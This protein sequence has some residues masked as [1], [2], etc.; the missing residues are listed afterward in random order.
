MSP[1]V[2]RRYHTFVLWVIVVMIVS[3]CSGR[4]IVTSAEDQAFQAAPPAPVVEET[5]VAPPTQPEEPEMR[6]EEEP[7]APVPETPLPPP[8]DPLSEL[9]DVYFDFDQYAIR[10]DAR[11]TLNRL[12]DLFKSEP[13]QELIIEG[14]CDERG[15]SAYNLVLGERR[16]QAAK[17]YLEKHGVASSQIQTASYGKERP[18]CTEHTEACW[19]SNRRVHFRKP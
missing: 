8:V 18:F 11:S 2:H 19:Q 14:H 13:N 9:S 15:T 7:I 4:R 17:Q 16:A 12:A 3:G 10:V 6:V 5:K 1:Q